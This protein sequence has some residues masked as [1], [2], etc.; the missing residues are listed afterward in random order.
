MTQR[1]AELEGLK[2]KLEQELSRLGGSPGLAERLADLERAEVRTGTRF[3]PFLASILY[4]SFE[5]GGA[6]VGKG[7]ST[8]RLHAINGACRCCGVCTQELLESERKHAEEQQALLAE[9]EAALALQR[10]AAADKE[11]E[12]A[13]REGA[14]L[15][16]SR[17]GA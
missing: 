9:A 2:V 17:G 12:L 11:E 1:E 7:A 10:K 8:W 14:Q 13:A 16:G 4:H 6:Q 3:G 15:Q 5:Q